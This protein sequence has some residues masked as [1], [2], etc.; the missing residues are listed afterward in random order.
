MKLKVTNK[1]YKQKLIDMDNSLVVT[2][3]KG[4]EVDRVKGVKYTVMEDLSLGG[5]HSEIYR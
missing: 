4:V 1:Q 5:E 2:R 3:E